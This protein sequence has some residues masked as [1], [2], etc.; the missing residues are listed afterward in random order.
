MNQDNLNNPLKL[1]QLYVEPTT[2][3][4]LNCRICVR[5]TWDEPIGLM[6]MEVYQKLMDGL[7]KLESLPKRVSFWGMGEP[8]VHPQI[9]NMVAEANQLGAE[10]LVISNGLLLDEEKAKGLVDAGL[11]RLILSIDGT[12]TTSQPDTRCGD[13]LQ[14]VIQNIKFFH[15]I[16]EVNPREALPICGSANAEDIIP[17]QKTK[18]GLSFVLTKSN[19]H[20]LKQL[21]SLAFTLGAS[22]I[23]FS[24]LLPYSEE[25]QDEILYDFSAGRSYPLE[26]AYYYPSIYYPE[27]SF[28]RIDVSPILF[29]V[30]PQLLGYTSTYGGTEPPVANKNGY[31]RF[32]EEGSIAVNWQGDVSPCIPLMHSYACYILGREKFFRKC[33]L[34]NIRQNNIEDIWHSDEFVRI[35]DTIKRFQFAPCTDCGGCTLAETNEEDCLNNTFPVCGDCLWAKGVIQCP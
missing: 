29:N 20:E 14:Q 18:I 33:V 25:V 12:S 10:T 32:V 34:G 22:S 2:L 9:V 19:L 15:T 4:N 13:V 11:D 5:K 28:P 3:C 30:L 7:R 23:T 1:T 17:Q 24:N 26:D 8:L 21:R 35:R 27:I 16:N 6:D 31:C